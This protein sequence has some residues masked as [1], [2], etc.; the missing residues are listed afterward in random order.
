MRWYVVVARSSSP[1][2]TALQ[3][4]G[5]SPLP[6]LFCRQRM[7]AAWPGG[8]S[9][10]KRLMASGH[11]LQGRRQQTGCEVNATT[12]HAH[13]QQRAC[14]E[15]ACTSMLDMPSPPPPTHTHTPH[16]ARPPA[17]RHALNGQALFNRG[18]QV[19]DPQLPRGTWRPH[20]AAD[21]R[22]ACSLLDAWVEAR[23]LV[24][25]S[26]NAF[27]GRLA[28][29]GQV[30]LGAAQAVVH[31][32]VAWLHTR[33]ELLDVHRTGLRSSS[34]HGRSH[35]SSGGGGSSSSSCASAWP[36]TRGGDRL[37]GPHANA[38]CLRGRRAVARREPR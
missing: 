21:P 10:Q 18:A 9:A 8:T 5:K 23:V 6:M 1:V 26:L 35:I 15:R 4:G 34:S 31:L 13:A 17:H 14:D 11:S 30:V 37:V 24:L 3:R 28:R 38:E 32:A 7:T 19:C 20:Q 12:R 27:L 22:P 33:A 29:G 25:Q 16:Y 2:I 36:Q